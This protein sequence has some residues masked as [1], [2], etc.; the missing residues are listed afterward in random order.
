MESQDSTLSSVL[1]IH[2]GKV[3]D[4][5]DVGEG[6]ILLVR[7][8]RVSGLNVK[9]TTLMPGKGVVLNNLSKWWMEGPLKGIVANH[10]T[11]LPRSQFV[12]AEELPKV[13]G[14]GEIV[15]QLKPVLIEA[16]VRRHI[17]GTGYKAY[18]EM[19]EI[20]GIKLSEGLKD[21][22]RLPEP[23]FTPTEKS[24]DDPAITF[25]RMC[26]L[27]GPELAGHIRDV[28]LK[29]FEV[30]EVRL[31]ERGII[32]ADT[33]FEFG[34]DVDG[35]LTLMDEVFTPDSSRF[36]LKEPF[37]REHKVVS[38]DKQKIRDW[39]KAQKEAGAW[40]GKSP[41]ALP[42]ALV[43]EVAADYREIY[44]R[45]TK[46]DNESD[47]ACPVVSIVMGSDSDWPVMKKV[48]GIL[49][50]FGIPYEARVLSAHRTPEAATEYAKSAKSRGIRVIIAGAGGAAHLAGVFAGHTTLPV[51]GVPM[52]SKLDGLDSLLST[53]QMPSGIPV[54]T[55][56]I[57]E[58]GAA[59]AALFA[60]AML[61]LSDEI[62]GQ[63]L[64][65]FRREQ[66]AKV[67]AKTLPDD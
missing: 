54:A 33:K 4:V 42:D 3:G 12:S 59:N 65:S 47:F 19:G 37:D 2:R 67:L 44:Q 49:R 16:V 38:L 21:G 24:D 25:E 26:E 29:I 15:K 10:L 61:A 34:L 64:I 35:N 66:T 9:S 53:V 31:L 60:V 32:L 48:A 55:F 11:G 45:I 22:D 6:L 63:K 62:L 50:Q 18:K 5:Y 39:M 36:W 20:C 27:V 56:A 7:S 43:A 58:A 30:A 17:T 57:G 52:T 28:S 46:E 8:D 13:E 23:I 40:D 51:L 14:R 41:I 1:L